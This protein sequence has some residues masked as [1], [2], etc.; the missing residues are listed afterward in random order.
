MTRRRLHY[1][2]LLA[3]LATS[4]APMPSLAA[5]MMRVPHS[6]A[7]ESEHAGP[8][9]PEFGYKKKLEKKKA[10]KKVDPMKAIRTRM[11]AGKAVSDP[12]WP[13]PLWDD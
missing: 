1:P 6:L 9:I 10:A 3:L 12:L 11:I 7:S 4:M 8:L 2:L 5:G 13:M